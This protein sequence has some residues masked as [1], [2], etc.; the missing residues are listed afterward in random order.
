MDL[1][2]FKLIAE[3]DKIG[4]I[5]WDVVIKWDFFCKDTIGKQVVRSA[6]SISANLSEAYGRFTNPERIR[7]IYYSR[8]SLCETINWIQ[9]SKKRNLINDKLAD[10]LLFQLNHLSIKQ[11]KYIRSLRASLKN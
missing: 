8:G 11:N 10:D 9:K 1:S 7:F 2:K 6:D 5:I 3:A 4:D